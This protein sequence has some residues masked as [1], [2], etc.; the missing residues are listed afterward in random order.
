MS[1]PQ[2]DKRLEAAAQI[3]AAWYGEQDGYFVE[4]R[5][6]VEKSQDDSLAVLK[7]AMRETGADELAGAL[8]KALA[9]FEGVPFGAYN[10][11]VAALAKYRSLRDE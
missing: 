8:I 2:A 1:E 11:C 5:E 7:T 6:A 10:R 3:V 9:D 4:S